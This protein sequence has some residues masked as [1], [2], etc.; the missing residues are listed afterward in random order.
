MNASHRRSR[1]GDAAQP[2]RRPRQGHRARRATPPSI[3]SPGLLYGWVVSSAIA[4]GRIAAIRRRGGARGARRRRDHHARE[5]AARRLARP[6][7][8]RRG[9]RPGLAVP[10]ALRRQDHVQRAAGGAGRRR[11]ASRRRATRAALVERRLRAPSRTTP[12]SRS[13]SPRSSSRSK[14][15][16][17]FAAAE[18]P[19][20]RR[21]GLRRGAAEASRPTITCRPTTTTRWRCTPPPWSGKA[22]AGSPSTTR[23]R[24]RRTSR[25]TSPSIFGF[26]KKNVRV[27]NPYVGGA[28]GSGL[29]P[30]YQVY[31]ATLAAKMLEALG[32]RR[33]DAPADVQPRAPAGG[34]PDRLARRRRA[35]AS[36]RRSSTTPPR[37]PRAS[38]T[39]WR[40]VCNWGLMNYACENASGEYTIAPLDTYTP[41]DM[42]APG[43]ATGMTLFEIAIDEMAYA[44]ERRSARLPPAQLFRR[45]TR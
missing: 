30:Q 23:R 20:R 25:P 19:R 21:S 44:A 6:Q 32:A 12:T 9:R 11:D 45:W 5:P 37:R 41:G 43:A 33:A 31:L 7:L 26:A 27:L 28:F 22:T 16:N 38:S 13:R 2:R 8:R 10:G 24:A 29:R 18:E 17:S 3:P 36:C 35:P 4:K 39:T 15:R 1:I 42:R 34:D 40:T 14:K